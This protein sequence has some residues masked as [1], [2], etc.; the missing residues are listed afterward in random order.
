MIEAAHAGAPGADAVAARAAGLLAALP[1]AQ[2]SS[3]AQA[4][5]DLM[6][7]SY[8]NGLWAAAHLINA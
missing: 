7:D 1:P 5:W 8:R 6:A 4:L 3:A 2:I